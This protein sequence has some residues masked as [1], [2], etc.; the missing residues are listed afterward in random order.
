MTANT[1]KPEWAQ[2]KREKENALR[3]S[4]GLK[5]KR[6]IMPWIVLGLLV[7]GGGAFV[8]MQPPAPEPVAVVDEAPVLKQILAAE[9]VEIAPTTLSQTIKV[10][11]S[12]VPGH[13]SSIASQASGRVLSV[14]VSPG[15]TVAEGAV[16]AEI[17]RAT[18][19][20]QLNQQRATAEATRIQLANSRQ[21]LERTEELARQGLT[22]PSNLEA[23]RSSTAA[24][25]SNL[26]ALE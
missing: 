20:L 21:Q 1:E 26:A 13:Q 22:S 6:R 4:Q 11:G 12:L 25:E 23:A 8:L 24:L 5:P 14:L 18:L 19:E 7:V 10:T 9:T 16:L 15:D 2:S 3:V 17:D